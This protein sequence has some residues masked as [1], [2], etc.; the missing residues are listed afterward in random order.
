MKL[1]CGTNNIMI[2][3]LYCMLVYLIQDGETALMLAAREGHTRIVKKLIWTGASVNLRNQVRR[4]Y[5]NTNSQ[6]MFA[7][8]PSYIS[9][10]HLG[11]KTL[12]MHSLL[13][14]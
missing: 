7:R 6:G 11:C 13:I 2:D 3:S 1:I 4:L 10:K 5:N 14:V 9:M 8:T 12:C